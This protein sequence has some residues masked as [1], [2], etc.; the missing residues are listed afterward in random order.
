KVFGPC[1]TGALVLAEFFDGE[2]R[3]YAGDASV[4]QNFAQLHWA[5]FREAGEIVVGVAYRRAQFDGLKSG[6]GKLFDGAGK[7]L[8]DHLPNRP[9]LA[10]DRQAQWVGH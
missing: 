5:V 3:A 2:M 8:G 6:L 10:S 4:A 9:G 7:I 1:D